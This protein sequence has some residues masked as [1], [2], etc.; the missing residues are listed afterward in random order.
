MSRL[1][2]LTIAERQFELMND[3]IRSLP[4]VLGVFPNFSIDE[5]CDCD[6]PE[7][8]FV[9]PFPDFE[10]EVEKRYSCHIEV[11]MNVCLEMNWD[12][13]LL[14]VGTGEKTAL[15]AGKQMNRQMVDDGKM[16]R[17]SLLAKT[18]SIDRG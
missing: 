2:I 6:V 18:R 10:R 16:T 5:S 1:I 13:L 12:V 8:W 3:T 14:S 7:D 11:Y 17:W 4:F 9:A 15:F